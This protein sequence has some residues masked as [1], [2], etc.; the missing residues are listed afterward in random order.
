MKNAGL[1]QWYAQDT[2][3]THDGVIVDLS[4]HVERLLD[5][6]DISHLL[7]E[8]QERRLVSWLKAAHEMSYSAI[9]RRYD[10]WR[11][12]DRA[13]DVYVPPDATSFREKA[14]IPDTRAIADTTIT[15]LMAALA[16]RNPMFQLEGLNRTS[17]KPALILERVLH[18]QLRRTAGEARLAQLLLDSVRYGY[19]PTK[20]IWHPK[21][22]QNHIVNF[23]PRRVFPDPRVSFGDWTSMQFIQF[24]DFS[25]FSALRRSGL[26]PKLDHFPQLA[27]RSAPPKIG[28]SGHRW[29]QEAGR[30]HS[31]DPTSSDTGMASGAG[32]NSAELFTLGPARVVDET[33]LTLAGHEIGVPQIRQIYLVATVLDEDTI[34][35]LSLNPYGQQFPVVTGAL[36]QDLHKTF[37]QGLYDLLLPMHDIA[38]YLMRARIDNI[39]AALN[40]LIFA[41]PSQIMIPDLIDR[42]P[43]GV[44]RTLPGGNPREGVFIAQ[45]PDVTRGHLQDIQALSELK[46]RVSAASDAQQ[47]MPTSDGIRTATEIQ[48]LTQLGS[49]RLGVLSR[50]MS[51]TTIRPLVRM[52]VTNIQDALSYDGSIRIE[53]DNTPNPLASSI[54][55]GYLDF[56]VSALQ[57]DIDYLVIDG[58]LPL[59]PTRNAETWMN[60]LQ[61]A[62]QT[63]L[64]MEYDL[65]QMAEEAI[66][67]MGVS[68]LDRFRISPERQQQLSPQQQL[69]MMERARG[70]SVQPQE[71][72]MS[73]VEK[74]NLVPMRAVDG[75]RGAQTAGG[76]NRK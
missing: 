20:L 50:V 10:H 49:Q 75:R 9:S 5:Y 45:V 2:P 29:H 67:A 74:G 23:D 30:G 69:S 18:Q 28:W 35:R 60:M 22:N 14:V 26:Y 32:S 37:G 66:R 4:E 58:T 24:T 39:S 6:Q 55:D 71:Q 31:I 27:Y 65:G 68:D 53:D 52:M 7:T 63:G 41:D 38:T 19:A 25:S 56:D 54:Q 40:N 15:Y 17:R 44:V 48:R 36:H 13:H 70:A 76:S 3:P 1:S 57:G 51:A 43:W 64:N 72:V 42:N 46:Q 61:I 21:T 47:G 11:E 16:G 59:E 12:A 34:I 8:E 33:W 73:E 62:N